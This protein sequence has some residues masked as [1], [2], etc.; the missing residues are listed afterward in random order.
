VRSY[1]IL[2]L[3]ILLTKYSSQIKV[4]IKYMVMKLIKQSDQ[5]KMLK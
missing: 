3:A 1:V 4:D 2:N 5:T